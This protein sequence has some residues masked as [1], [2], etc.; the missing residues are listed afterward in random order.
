MQRLGAAT[1]CGGVVGHSRSPPS[2][3]RGTSISSV[4]EGAVAA[5]QAVLPGVG[6]VHEG[7][8]LE[9]D[10]GHV[11]Q[12]VGEPAPSGPPNQ[13]SST[14]WSRVRTQVVAP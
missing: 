3:T 7:D 10:Q 13:P 1:V 14:S 4:G 6:G 12:A 2:A 11:A 9:R 8:G 5:G